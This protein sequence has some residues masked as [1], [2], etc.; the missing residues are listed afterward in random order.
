MSGAPSSQLPWSW[1]VGVSWN[2]I[3][4]HFFADVNGAMWVTDHSGA[5][6]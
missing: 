5:T 4:L 3:P 2:E 6:G 1:A